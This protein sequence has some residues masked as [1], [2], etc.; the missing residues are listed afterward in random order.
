VLI[1]P[2][3]RTWT[4]NFRHAY[5]PTCDNANNST[6]R[7]FSY[8][9]CT[10]RGRQGMSTCCFTGLWGW[11]PPLHKEV[12]SMGYTWP[13]DQGL[14]CPGVNGWWMV[15]HDLKTWTQGQQVALTALIMFAAFYAAWTTGEPYSSLGIAAPYNNSPLF[16]TAYHLIRL[17]GL[18]NLLQLKCAHFIKTMKY[19]Q[20]ICQLPCIVCATSLKMT[21]N[22]D[23]CVSVH[24][25]EKNCWT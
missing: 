8:L 16:R 24:G 6:C 25:V 20:S 11:E 21:E 23:W 19:K 12:Y 18:I 3:I 15:T 7:L 17:F 2:I 22:R 10:M 4:R 13:W 1:N 14:Q 5:H 9:Y